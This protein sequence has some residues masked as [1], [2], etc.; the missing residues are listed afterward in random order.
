MIVILKMEMLL[1]VFMAKIISYNGIALGMDSRGRDSGKTAKV[2][3]EAILPQATMQI[4]DNFQAPLMK[5]K[6][7]NG[8]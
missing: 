1:I 4:Y 3:L 2:T 5:T 6:L 8:T 7:Q